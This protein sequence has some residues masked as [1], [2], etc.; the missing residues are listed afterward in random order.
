MRYKLRCAIL[1]RTKSN[2]DCPQ[3]SFG[4]RTPSP[5]PR[6][7]SVKSTSIKPKTAQHSTKF[8]GLCKHDKTVQ[9]LSIHCPANTSPNCRR[10][11]TRQFFSKVCSTT[12]IIPRVLN[13]G[14]EEGLTGKCSSLRT[15]ASSACPVIASTI[16]PST[17]MDRSLYL[18]VPGG[19]Q[20]LSARM[21]CRTCGQEESS[22]KPDFLYKER[23]V[24][25]LNAQQSLLFPSPPSGA[26]RARHC[27]GSINARLS[28]T[29]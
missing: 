20:H 25:I 21:N 23:C 10:P 19:Y 29:T 1:F 22:K 26:L 2:N 6:T 9:L 8:T 18:V 24:L 27:A 3:I 12:Q 14:A 4:K 16:H 17:I 11:K 15:K 13:L 28:V 5:S 7:L